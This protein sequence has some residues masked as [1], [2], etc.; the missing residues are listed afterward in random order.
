MGL[1]ADRTAWSLELALHDALT[2]QMLANMSDSLLAR[3]DWQRTWRAG[4]PRS[5]SLDACA[6]DCCAAAERHIRR[7]ERALDEAELALS[8]ADPKE[9][10]TLRVIAPE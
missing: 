4:S 6:V 9:A 2:A 1:E 5:H 8:A 7:V 10:P 3:A